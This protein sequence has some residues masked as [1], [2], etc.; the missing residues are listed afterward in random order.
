MKNELNDSLIKWAGYLLLVF[1]LITVSLTQYIPSLDGPQHLHTVNVLAE[2]LKGNK[3]IDQ[4]YDIN[5]IP[6]GYWSA[7]FIL[8]FFFLK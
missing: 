1:S 6:V 3:F 2:L 7:H 5:S 8:G 4:F